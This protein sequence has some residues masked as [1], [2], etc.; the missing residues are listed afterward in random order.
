[1]R[2]NWNIYLLVLSALLTAVAYGQQNQPRSLAYAADKSN[3]PDA[4]AKL[5]SGNFLLVHID[6]I[7]RAGAV[8][9]VPALKEQFTRNPDP[10][11][12]AKIASALVRL[13][14]R[15]D[16]YWDFLVKQTTPALES[17]APD[18]LNF[19]PQ[20]KTGSGPSPEFVAWANAHGQDPQSAGRDAMYGM[21]GR[22]TLLASAGDQRA[23]PLLRRA[24]SSPNH[25]IEMTAAEG[26]AE[27]QDKE[28][29]PLI[30]E[31]CK[32]A[33]AGA[34]QTIAESLVYFDDSEAQS[35]VDKYVPEE[36]AKI[37]RDAKAQGKKTPLD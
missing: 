29:I 31:A 1:M 14:D 22:L 26:L 5:K 34:A 33:P 13:G 8:E 18:F 32:R 28:S 11:V 4:I 9:A 25:M 36:R 16:L 15:D 6:M 23:I 7:A 24:L 30:I 17:D 21:P 10:L 3:V 35:T 2:I 37:L 27:L 20:A 12:K 19:A